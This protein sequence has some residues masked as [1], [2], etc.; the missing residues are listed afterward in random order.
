MVEECQRQLEDGELSSYARELHT[1]RALYIES[2][3]R[4]PLMDVKRRDSSVDSICAVWGSPKRHS[5]RFLGFESSHESEEASETRSSRFPSASERYTAQIS[6][7]SPNL[8]YT[9]ASLD[10]DLHQSAW[11]VALATRNRHREGDATSIVMGID[12]G[13]D[14]AMDT[15]MDMGIGMVT[16]MVT[17]TVINIVI[18]AIITRNQVHLGQLLCQNKASQKLAMSNDRRKWCF[19]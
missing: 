10:Y 7:R 2:L 6:T 16:A 9:N 17:A 13:I 8:G 18:V 1:L 5:E 19:L 3:R 15:G 11:D 4:T 14:I 12:I